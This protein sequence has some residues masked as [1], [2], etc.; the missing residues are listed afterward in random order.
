M[1]LGRVVSIAGALA[2]GWFFFGAPSLVA[3][4]VRLQNGDRLTGRVL[5]FTNGTFILTNDT[6]GILR[7][8]RTHVQQVY[9]GNAAPIESATTP[10]LARGKA[11]AGVAP[12]TQGVNPAL[13]LQNSPLSSSLASL[14]NDTNLV[15]SVR[16]QFLNGA[17]PEAHSKFNEMLGGLLTGKLSEND[18][19]AEARSAAAQLRAARKEMGDD[20]GSAIDD[21]LAILDRFVGSDEPQQVAKKK[22]PGK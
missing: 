19:R 13:A 22:N 18:I 4:E 14:G 5:D 10:P 9:F 3:D 16:D 20:A 1:K 12:S 15:Q 2:A 21:Y 17:T 6:L 7:I 11:A 8:P